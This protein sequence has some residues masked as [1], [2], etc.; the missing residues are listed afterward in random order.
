MYTLLCAS[1][2]FT[3]LCARASTSAVI[4]CDNFLDCRI[5]Q[6]EVGSLKVDSGR[7]YNNFDITNIGCYCFDYAF[8]SVAVV[9][10]CFDL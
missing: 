6:S 8:I 3:L 7:S 10:C 4:R 2:K 5:T 9:V 1:A